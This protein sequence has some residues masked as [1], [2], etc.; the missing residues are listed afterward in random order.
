MMGSVIRSFVRTKGLKLQLL[1]S[2][3]N[4]ERELEE[5]SGSGQR[6]TDTGIRLNIYGAKGHPSKSR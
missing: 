5:D 3:A 2:E 1:L 4:A 6:W